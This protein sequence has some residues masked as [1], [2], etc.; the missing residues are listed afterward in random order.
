MSLF[1]EV[2]MWMMVLPNQQCIFLKHVNMIFGNSFS[3]FTL[4]PFLLSSNEVS[5]TL[6]VARYVAIFFT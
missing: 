3:V 1:R 2:P 5:R 4:C 6:C